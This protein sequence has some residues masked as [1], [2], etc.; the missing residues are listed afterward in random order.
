[1]ELS[2][3]FLSM[4]ETSLHLIQKNKNIL[5]GKVPVEGVEIVGEK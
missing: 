1:M 5:S 3:S 2:K 4:S